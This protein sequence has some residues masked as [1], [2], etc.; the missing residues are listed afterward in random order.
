MSHRIQGKETGYNIDKQKL[1]AFLY[2]RNEQLQLETDQN[3][4]STRKKKEREGEKE[5]ERKKG[6]RKKKVGRDG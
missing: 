4:S 3:C 1:V 5:R 2:T 6:E